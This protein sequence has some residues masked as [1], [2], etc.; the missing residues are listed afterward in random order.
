MSQSQQPVYSVASQTWILRLRV[1][2]VTA[3]STFWWG[4][5]WK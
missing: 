5:L 2:F 1:E 3:S 4:F